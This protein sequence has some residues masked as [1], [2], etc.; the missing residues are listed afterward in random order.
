MSE[1]NRIQRT[2]H[3]LLDSYH[4]GDRAQIADH[5]ESLAEHNRNGGEH[6]TIYRPVNQGNTTRLIVY[7][8]PLNGSAPCCDSVVSVPADPQSR[9]AV[10]QSCVGQHYCN[11]RETIE[12]A[13]WDGWYPEVDQT[14][15]LTG[16]VIEENSV[17]HT[18]VGVVTDSLIHGG[19]DAMIGESLIEELITI[20]YWAGVQQLIAYAYGYEA[21]LIVAAK[22]NNS[23]GPYYAHGDHE[24]ADDGQGLR[25]VEG[26]VGGVEYAC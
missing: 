18:V 20:T 15:H 16:E 13:N 7:S 17:N 11:A 26:S 4:R 10:A 12:S 2:L 3:N 1:S 14:G 23:F 8:K 9:V 19:S 25:Y 24:L 22:N 21:S 6:P 5:L